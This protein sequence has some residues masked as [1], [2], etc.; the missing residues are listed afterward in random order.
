MKGVYHL[1][2]Y[3]PVLLM[4]TKHVTCNGLS[5]QGGVK[6]QIIKIMTNWFHS[7]IQIQRI[8]FA[9]THQFTCI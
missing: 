1:I 7:I 3:L 6:Q 2:N 5:R 8:L 9:Y 4:V